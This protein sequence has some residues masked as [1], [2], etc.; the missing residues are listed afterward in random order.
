MFPSILSPGSSRPPTTAV[1]IRTRCG[2]CHTTLVWPDQP[3]KAQQACGSSPAASA[4]R[5]SL[6]SRGS[7]LSLPKRWCWSR[8][9]LQPSG[10]PRTH[11]IDAR[12]SPRLQ[13][14]GRT[15]SCIG[16][17]PCAPGHAGAPRGVFP[18]C[19][20][21]PQTVLAALAFASRSAAEAVGCSHRT[22]F[23]LHRETDPAASMSRPDIYAEV[24]DERFPCATVVD[25]YAVLPPGLTHHCHFRRRFRESQPC[26]RCARQSG[27]RGQ[28]LAARPATTGH[29]R[30]GARS[31]G[32]ELSPG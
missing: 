12:P 17:R 6:L 21:F 19:P 10:C 23:L 26:A 13:R 11:S 31:P 14:E 9:P 2:P 29:R 7:T 4:S 1:V 20:T 22:V 24:L 32:Q 28:P 30:R 16:L 15:V 8:H 3:P 18:L 25:P 5:A 27:S